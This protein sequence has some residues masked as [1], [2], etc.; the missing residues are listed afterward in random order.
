MECHRCIVWTLVFGS[1]FPDVLVRTLHIK[2]CCPN[3][4]RLLTS[5]RYYEKVNLFRLKWE[6]S[7]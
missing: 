3:A 5:E 4:P 6:G 2:T 7:R 1:E